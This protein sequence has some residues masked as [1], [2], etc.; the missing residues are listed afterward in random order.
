MNVM[1][2]F[3]HSIAF[4]IKYFGFTSYEVALIASVISD[5]VNMTSPPGMFS[6]RPAP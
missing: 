4:N 2:I 1:T 6:V 5:F 3:P